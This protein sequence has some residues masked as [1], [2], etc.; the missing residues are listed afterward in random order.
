MVVA[1]E[2]GGVFGGADA[3]RGSAWVGL[4]WLGKDRRFG[5]FVA[6]KETNARRS[7]PL[8]AAR[9]GKGIVDG[10]PSS[11]GPLPLP[12][13]LLSPSVSVSF[14]LVS[15]LLVTLHLHTSSS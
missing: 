14:P 3:R 4:G 6:K 15:P 13:T 2:A 1:V 11:S 5:N 9:E 10:A 7:E 12:L 8:S